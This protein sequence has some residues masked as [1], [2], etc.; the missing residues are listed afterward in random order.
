MDARELYRSGKLA[1]AVAAMNE[2]VRTHPADANR[3]GFLCELLCAAGQ[4]ERADKLLEALATQDPQSAP[5]VA[6][7]RQ[8]VRAEQARQQMW[9]DGR[10]PEFVGGGPTPA[11]K[12]L[13]QAIVELR[14]G[15]AAEAL[16][17][18]SQA[19]EARPKLKGTCDGEAFTDLR[20]LEDLSCSH[21]EVLTSTGKYFW[22]PVESVESVEFRAPT[23][24]RDLLWR[25]AHM[26]VRGGPDGEVF[27]PA[28]Y[29][30]VPGADD[31]AR[32][33]RTTD[34]RGGEGAPVQGVGQRTL[35][36]G[37]KARPMLEIKEIQIE[38][39]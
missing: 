9:S 25:R 30:G 22:I 32:L 18:V 28:V 36:V 6:I 16:A 17:L 4:L 3:R 35:L 27:L 11:Q 31:A 21:F 23:R 15:R 20:D 2:E 33:A 10:V 19:D 38:T 29:A 8:I 39:A 5:A 37:D 1:E 13:L 7:F 26:V 34:W 24:P 12:A 14:A